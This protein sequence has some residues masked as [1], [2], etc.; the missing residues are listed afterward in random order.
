MGQNVDMRR[1]D[2][3]CTWCFEYFY[4]KI[5]DGIELKFDLLDI[6]L[7]IEVVYRI[8]KNTGSILK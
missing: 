5:S 6:G 4:E 3:L 2:F 7:G 8:I 1:W